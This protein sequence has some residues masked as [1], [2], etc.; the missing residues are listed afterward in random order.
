MKITI[1]AITA[2]RTSPYSSLLE[3][4]ERRIQHYFDLSVVE[5]P[6]A[7]GGSV[8]PEDARKVEGEVLLRRIPRNNEVF[9][10]SR[11]GK[12]LS[13]TGLAQHLRKLSTS[14]RSGAAFLI[15]GA[16]GLPDEVLAGAHRTLS[17]SPMTLPHEMAR[18]LLT[19]QLYRAGT[20]L[21]GEPYHKG[22]G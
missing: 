5:V 8:L 15:G 11:K 7:R 1:M 17:L 21:R 22:G 19:E 12:G 18:L 14:A 10:V 16:N 2:G 6:P 20:I 3:E 9:A 4:Y 13:S